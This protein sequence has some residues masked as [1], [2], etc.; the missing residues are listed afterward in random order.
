MTSPVFSRRIQVA[1]M[2]GGAGG[3]WVLLL[4]CILLMAPPLA[5]GAWLIER[6]D[7]VGVLGVWLSI[8]LT[9][10]VCLV[11]LL[12]WAWL[13]TR[14]RTWRG[15]PALFSAMTQV[16][17]DER[18]LA[19]QTLGH[20]EWIDVLAIEGIPDSSSYL[21]V[22]T[23]TFQKLMMSAPVD[24]LA[25]VISH[26]LAKKNV[27]TVAAARSPVLQLRAVVF[28]WPRFIA[29]IWAGYAVAGVV[30]L[31]LL[32]HAND[33]GFFKTLVAL[34]VLLPLSAWLVWMI[35]LAQLDVLAPSRVRA[36]ELEDAALRSTDDAVRIDLRRARIDLRSVSGLGYDFSFF[37]VRPEKGPRLDL[38]LGDDDRR[39]LLDVLEQRGL[40]QQR[41]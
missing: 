31:V 14:W 16:D 24:E 1:Q 9:L 7:V 8:A 40:M 2:E 25:E 12:V 32:Q 36:F 22:H 15:K 19:V 4:V 11:S 35:P 38:I 33:A 37:R 5:A 6:E 27:P 34:G 18:G 13:D 41:S 30:G 17:I 23:R 28:R 26:Y 20:I 39:A 10:V 21:V 3:M 29:W